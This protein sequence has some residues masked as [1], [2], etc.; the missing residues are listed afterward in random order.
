MNEEE[1]NVQGIKETIA[2][3]EAQKEEAEKQRKE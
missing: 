1:I 3:L 2:K